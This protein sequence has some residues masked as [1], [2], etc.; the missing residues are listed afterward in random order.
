VDAPLLDRMSRPLPRAPADALGPTGPRMG[1]YAG[2]LG[3]VDLSALAPE[4]LLA[5]VR[6]AAR[7]KRWQRVVLAGPSHLVIA[8]VLDGGAVAGGSLWVVDRA[9]GEVRWDR[10]VTGLPG[11]NARVGERP[12]AG[13]RV[14]FA[15]P[16]FALTLE[17]RSDRYQ[18]EA[19]LGEALRLEVL[20]DARGAPEPF[21]LVAPL[22]QE[23]V[24]ATQIGGPLAVTGA[25]TLRGEH[26]RLDGGLAVLDYGTGLFPREA[27]WRKVTGVGRLPDGRPLALHLAEGLEGVAPDDGGEDVLLL[28]PG[29]HRLPAVAMQ[30][31]AGSASAPWRLASADGQV[32]LTFQPAASHREGRELLLVSTSATQLCGA[33]SGRVPAPGGAVLELDGL[34]AVAEDFSAR[35]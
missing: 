19:D 5:S 25:L 9:T 2:S 20:L 35:W 14:T 21:A 27:A 11:L 10:S 23:G 7:L 17:R 28:G 6:H 13:A 30:A 33:L 1:A 18:L 16:G 3:R 26:H 24:R 32:D 8:N 31:E 29:P 34:P 22:P 4:G 15:G 12:G